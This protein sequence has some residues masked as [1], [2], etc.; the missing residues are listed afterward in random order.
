MKAPVL[1]FDVNETLLDM[2]ALDPLFEEVF[3]TSSMRQQWFLTLQGLWMTCTLTKR[4]VPFDKLARAAL[5]MTAR[6][7]GVLLDGPVRTAILES[8]KRLPPHADVAMA[9][10]TLRDTG[11]R[12]AALSNGTSQ[13]IRT[14]LRHAGLFDKFDEVISVDQIEVYKPAGEPYRFAA[15][16]F[17]AKPDRVSLVAAHHWDLAGAKAAGL[18]TVFVRRPGAVLNPLG[19]KPDIEVADLEEFA[20]QVAGRRRRRVR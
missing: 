10:D 8:V 19:P 3:G 9:L 11:L 15:R 7:Q 17:R 6:R 2:R 20:R 14:Q 5:D 16:R 4:F 13:G 18:T 12:L 1:L